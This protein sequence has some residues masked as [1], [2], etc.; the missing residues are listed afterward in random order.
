[1][2]ERVLFWVNRGPTSP[3]FPNPLPQGEG[4]GRVNAGCADRDGSACRVT[5]ESPAAAHPQPVPALLPLS[6][7]TTGRTPRRGLARCR[8]VRRVRRSEK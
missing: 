5:D 4:T 2:R 8:L 6:M 7:T 3:P 1:M